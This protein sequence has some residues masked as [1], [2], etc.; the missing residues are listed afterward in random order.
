[1]QGDKLALDAIAFAPMLRATHSNDHANGS[2][3]TANVKIASSSQPTNK[4]L[5]A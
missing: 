4:P 2:T 1:M 5:I 3:T